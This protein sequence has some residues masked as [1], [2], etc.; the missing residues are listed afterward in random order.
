MGESFRV[1]Q[2]DTKQGQS[3][4]KVKVEIKTSRVTYERLGLVN[5]L[6][7]CLRILKRQISLLEKKDGNQR[8]IRLRNRYRFI[9]G[10]GVVRDRPPIIELVRCLK[11]KVV[12]K[13]IVPPCSIL[14]GLI[15]QFRWTKQQLITGL[16][17]VRESQEFEVKKSRYSTSIIQ[18]G[19]P[20]Y[21]TKTFRFIW[22]TV[23]L[24]DR[25]SSKNYLFW[26]GIVLAFGLS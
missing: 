19:F 6:L 1:L 10:E 17:P 21:V 25:V 12:R 18:L 15:P 7:I 5:T 11:N 23:Y 22:F 4:C 24:I 3:N 2:N 16:V 13:G 26:V 9:Y 20:S 14:S 8:I